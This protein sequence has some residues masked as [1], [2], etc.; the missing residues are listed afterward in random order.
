MS[1]APLY[2]N[3]EHKIARRKEGGPRLLGTALPLCS[4]EVWGLVFEIWTRNA[5]RGLLETQQYAHRSALGWYLSLFAS[6]SASL[7]RKHHPTLGLYRAPRVEYCGIL[8][9]GGTYLCARI[10]CNLCTGPTFVHRV[11]ATTTHS[12][13]S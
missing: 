1:E 3:H 8:G 9:K 5:P 6:V 11:C 13:N 10:P 7:K 4:R 2:I 12:E